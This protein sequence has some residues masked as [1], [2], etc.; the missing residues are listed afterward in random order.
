[1]NEIVKVVIGIV[2]EIVKEIVI[3]NVTE[4]VL[5]ADTEK[6]LLNILC[7]SILNTFYIIK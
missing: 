7:Y 5:V 6:G 4:T 1:M 3:V 2:K